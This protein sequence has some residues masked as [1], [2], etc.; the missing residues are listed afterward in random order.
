MDI[1]L[2]SLLSS[3]LF[4]SVNARRNPGG[5]I[6][7]RGR[8]E[9]GRAAWP[10]KRWKSFLPPISEVSFELQLGAK[11]ALTL[12][13][14]SSAAVVAVL[15]SAA[16]VDRLNAGAAGNVVLI[17]GHRYS[18]PHRYIAGPLPSALVGSGTALDVSNGVTLFIPLGDIPGLSNGVENGQKVQVFIATAG[19]RVGES[20][21]NPDAMSAWRGTGLYRD[22]SVEWDAGN[23]F[24]KVYPS[25]SIDMIWNYFR[26]DPRA[27]VDR[28]PQW[29]AACVRMGSTSSAVSGTALCDTIG[30]VDGIEVKVT[31]SSKL[32]GDAPKLLRGVS[33][34][35]ETWKHD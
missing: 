1:R 5:P 9:R 11:L 25:R 10:C 29:V 18:I 23:G 6:F 24:Y 2:R 22:R 27:G 31:L 3:D 8:R 19:E 28:S 30:H 34:L 14:F 7:T 4:Q 32:V 13:R 17:A 15:A 35:I 12:R 20:D 33:E 21:L 16:G 26:N